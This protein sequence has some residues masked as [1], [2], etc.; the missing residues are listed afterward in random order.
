MGAKLQLVNLMEQRLEIL[1]FTGSSAL[2]AK[3]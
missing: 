3:I 2:F 1:D